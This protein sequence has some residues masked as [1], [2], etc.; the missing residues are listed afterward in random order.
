MSERS[1]TL[2]RGV[3]LVTGVASGCRRLTLFDKDS[4]GLNATKAAIKTVSRDADPGVLI[5]H[6]DNIDT[7][8]VGGNMELSIKHF[9]ALTMPSTV[10]SH[11][12]IPEKSD[13]VINT[14]LRGLWLFAREELKSL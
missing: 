12:A 5:R 1:N 9:D 6:V 8:E 7:C 4:T 10:L 11:E 3:A 2:F 14:N 13:H